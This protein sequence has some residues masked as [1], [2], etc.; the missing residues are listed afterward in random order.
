MSK[1]F[2]TSDGVGDPMRCLI[3]GFVVRD[4]GGGLTEVR[5]AREEELD[6][7]CGGCQQDFIDAMAETTPV[8]VEATRPDGSK[9]FIDDPDGRVKRLYD[10]EQAVAVARNK[11]HQREHAKF[12]E[13]QNAGIAALLKGATQK[14]AKEHA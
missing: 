10:N 6:F 1:Q 8:L 11:R 7:S 2:L 3:C 12:V 4:A 13:M 5:N 14:T 9:W